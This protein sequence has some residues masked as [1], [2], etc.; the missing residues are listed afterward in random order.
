M[1][2]LL[3]LLVE[4]AWEVLDV[5][6]PDQVHGL[7][8]TF[9]GEVEVWDAVVKLVRSHCHVSLECDWSNGAS[10]RKHGGSGRWWVLV[11]CRKRIC[12]SLL[13]FVA[14]KAK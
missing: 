7:L 11:R 10:R 5:D 2:C 12:E 4:L 13:W 6:I 1:R 9:T 8:D 14:A 3:Y